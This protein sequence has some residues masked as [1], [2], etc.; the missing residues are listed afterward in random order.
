VVSYSNEILLG[1]RVSKSPQF[2]V[3]PSQLQ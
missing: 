3:Q 2:A 1:V